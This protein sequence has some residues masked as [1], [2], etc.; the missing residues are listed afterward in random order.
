[1]N[2]THASNAGPSNLHPAGPPSV[3]RPRTALL[4]LY[5]ALVV[6]LAIWSILASRVNLHA[7]F[8]QADQGTEAKLVVGGTIWLFVFTLAVT[9]AT[10]SYRRYHK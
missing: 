7:A 10:I 1:M 6:Q 5:A 4:A 9:G 3:H 8:T 2:A